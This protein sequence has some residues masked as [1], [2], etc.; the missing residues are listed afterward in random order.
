MLRR[1]HDINYPCAQYY[2]V[3]KS[4]RCSCFV[5]PLLSN[6]NWLPQKT[7]EAYSGGEGVKW[8][9]LDFPK[10]KCWNLRPFCNLWREGERGRV[11]EWHNLRRY[12]DLVN[13]HVFGN[14]LSDRYNGNLHKKKH[15]LNWKKVLGRYFVVVINRQGSR[16]KGYFFSGPSTKALPLP[17]PLVRLPLRR[18]AAAVMRD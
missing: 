5:G 9:P 6:T 16:K 7:P 15:F 12:C 8:T 10:S 2:P 14:D 3:C 1:N 13:S 17:P 4:G 18:R 11:R